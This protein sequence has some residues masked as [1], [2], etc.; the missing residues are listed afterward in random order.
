MTAF[1]IGIAAPT[2]WRRRSVKRGQ[3]LTVRSG[4]NLPFLGRG[5]GPAE[6]EPES[7]PPDT[8]LRF[9]RGCPASESGAL[10]F[11]VQGRPGMVNS[12]DVLLVRYQVSISC[13]QVSICQLGG[14]PAPVPDL[15]ANGRTRIVVRAWPCGPGRHCPFARRADGGSLTRF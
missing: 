13:Q 7:G 5:R 9:L 2:S 6:T 8:F 12:G 3:I 15:P 10:Q 4:R 1:S 11:I 14:L